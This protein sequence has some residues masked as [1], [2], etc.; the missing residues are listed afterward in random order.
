MSNRLVKLAKSKKKRSKSRDKKR[1][2]SPLRFVGTVLIGLIGLASSVFA[3]WPR[4]TVIASDPPDPDHP[5]S[6]SWTITN[7]GPLL[8]RSVYP[9]VAIGRIEVSINGSPPV[10]IESERPYAAEIQHDNWTSRDIGMDEKVSFS[11]NDSPN[12]LPFMARRDDLYSA[13]LAIIVHYELPVI[14]LR[15]TKWFYFFAK[16]QTNGN[17]YWYSDANPNSAHPSDVH[18]TK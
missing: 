4:V 12:I 1:R 5:F 15:Q 9:T 3:F 16:K 10:P 17:F 14:H 6:S 11:L 13:K 7:N 18:T 2:T 8:L